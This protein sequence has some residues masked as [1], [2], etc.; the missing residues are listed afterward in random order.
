MR[1][2]QWQHCIA[3]LK[4]FRYPWSRHARCTSMDIFL[5]RQIRLRYL[6]WQHCIGTYMSWPSS[7]RRT[8]VSTG[9]SKNGRIHFFFF[10]ERREEKLNEGQ[11]SGTSSVV[12]LPNGLFFPA[13]ETTLVGADKF[14][15][16]RC[17]MGYSAYSF[18]AA[19]L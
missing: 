11:R 16:R 3:I 1:Y 18:V 9:E 10:F 4:K 5:A 17:Y 12:Y 8:R 13:M 14:I 19:V 15:C 6:Q 7:C 2:L